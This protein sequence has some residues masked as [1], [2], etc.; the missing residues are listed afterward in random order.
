MCCNCSFS[1]PIRLLFQSYGEPRPTSSYFLAIIKY[2]AIDSHLSTVV[3]NNGIVPI[4]NGII[5]HGGDCI[6]GNAP[7][8]LGTPNMV[9]SP[10]AEEARNSILHNKDNRQVCTSIY[11]TLGRQDNH[12][13]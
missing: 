3:S 9:D 10:S 1:S 8:M 12:P 11:P 13:R 6:V 5:C 4:N 2:N 7:H